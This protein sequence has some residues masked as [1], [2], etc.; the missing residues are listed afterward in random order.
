MFAVIQTGG[1][2]YTVAPGDEISVEKLEGQAGDNIV[3]ENVLML[4]GDK[5][6]TV[7]APLVE[8]ASV[9]AELL[10]NARDKKVIV[11]KKR[12]RQ[13]YRR[14]A[15]H[16]QW[17]SKLRI[18]EILEP[19][20]KKPAAKKA[21]P[22]KTAGDADTK[23]AAKKPAAKKAAPKKAA[24]E[25]KAAAKKPAAKKAAPKKAAAKKPAAKKSED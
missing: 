25:T 3:I 24:G 4:G 1:K 18:A 9:V 2:Q 21:A 8:G 15:G 10:E 14:K 16:R 11:F 23:P 5:G 12:R 19:G 6:V 17:F 7:G 22:A 20:A 13:N